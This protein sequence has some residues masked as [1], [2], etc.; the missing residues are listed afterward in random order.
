M[1]SDVSYLL[2][3]W[4]KWL[5]HTESTCIFITDGTN[6][7]ICLL[8]TLSNCINF[9]I[10][11]QSMATSNYFG[12][13]CS[14]LLWE[15]WTESPPCHS[16]VFEACLWILWKVWV[17]SFTT[18]FERLLKVQSSVHYNNVIKIVYLVWSICVLVWQIL[19]CRLAVSHFFISS[20]SNW[21]KLVTNQVNL[22]HNC[23][24]WL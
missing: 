6:L 17:Y 7:V 20:L 10:K 11:C 8:L 12:S 13:T 2:L 9:C 21:T 1:I 24:K 14:R 22:P 16:D 18:Y 23:A 3:N 5:C 19:F 15:N 4:I